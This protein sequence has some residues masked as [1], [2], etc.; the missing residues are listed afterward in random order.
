MG[1]D[2][3]SDESGKVDV[4]QDDL[5]GTEPAKQKP[6]HFYQLVCPYIHITY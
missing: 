4:F 2:T 3:T 6:L 1:L 5:P